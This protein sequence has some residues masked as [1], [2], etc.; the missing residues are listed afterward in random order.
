MTKNDVLPEETEEIATKEEEKTAETTKSL[1]E[2]LQEAK[3]QAAEYLDGWQRARAE[4]ANLKKRTDAEREEWTRLANGVLVYQLLPVVDDFK[5]AED[6]LPDN[7]RRL[8]W[9]DGVLLILRKLQAILDAAGLEPI[10]AQ[11]QPFDPQRHDAVLYETVTDPAL[12]NYVVQEL[13]KGYLFGGKVLRPTM[14]KVG[15]MESQV[16]SNQ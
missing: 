3:A 7:L 4:F 13:Q 14:V 1:E 2:Q 8:T 11:G 6:T 9:V 16:T 5:R 10:Q 12:D 15:R